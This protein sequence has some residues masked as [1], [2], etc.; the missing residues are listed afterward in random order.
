MSL[1][2]DSLPAVTAST[3]HSLPRRWRPTPLV[4]ASALVH[5][6]AAGSLLVAPAAWP[7]AVGGVIADHLLLTAAGLWPRSTLL[8]PNWVRLPPSAVARRQVALT[9]DDGPDPEITPRVLDVLDLHRVRA[10]FFCIGTRVA[11]HPELARDIVRR[12]HTIENHS[13]QHLHR[14]SVLGPRAMAAEVAAAQD[15]IAST[16][17]RAPQFFRA[18][19]GLRNPF[20]DPVLSR[21][22]LR[23][24]SWTRRGFDTVAQSPATVV[25]RL[26]RNLAAGDILLL[27]DGH[28][29][30]T[31]HGSAVILEALPAV[32]GALRNRALEPITLSMAL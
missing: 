21:L 20:L 27:H 6:A 29:A 30:R 11:A 9:I 17:G 2:S 13:Q 4:Q 18:P 25:S 3:D 23:L 24:A 22:S 16:V 14:F 8:G 12:G 10:T 26:L 5:A 31:Q 1:V 19:A 15:T 7:W 28:A 32:I